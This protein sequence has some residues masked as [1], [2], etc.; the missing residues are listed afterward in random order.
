MAYAVTV[1]TGSVAFSADVTDS[2]VGSCAPLAI[3]IIITNQT[4][5]IAGSRGNTS[6]QGS[7]T[8][9]AYRDLLATGILARD[10]QELR[11]LALACMLAEVG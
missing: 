8:A 5:P 3:P 6:H 2:W 7:T 10:S 1:D 4:T 11:I 9:H